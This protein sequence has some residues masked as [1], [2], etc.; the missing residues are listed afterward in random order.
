MPKHLE[1]RVASLARL[2]LASLVVFLVGCSDAARPVSVDP[3]ASIV[4]GTATGSAYGAV[5]ALLYD[6][7]QD[8][9]I[10]GDDEVCT[11]TLV[12][13]TVFLTAAHCVLPDQYIPAGAQ[14]HVSFAPDLYA[15]N[16]TII[17]ASAVEADPDYGGSQASLHDLAVVTLPANAT[18]GITPLRLP[19]AGALDQLAAQNGLRRSSFV[20]VGYGTSATRTGVP[21]FPFD[22]KRRMSTSPFMAL[23][24]TWLGLLMNSAAT[25]QGGDC[26]GDSG[27]PKFLEGDATTIYAVV[28]TGDMNCRAT[29]WDWR[30]D[31]PEAR[32]FLSAFVTLP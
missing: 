9:V 13:P 15:A 19:T 31:T 11:G 4:N 28:V 32:G 20:S 16:I 25:G 27:G 3:T 29:S 10:D 8:G 26:Y 14:F 6:Y 21:S 22:G 30:L 17:D 2:S 24:P 7:D 12:A 5:G 18:A 23:Q 1:V